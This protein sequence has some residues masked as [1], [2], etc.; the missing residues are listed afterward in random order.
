MDKDDV[1]GKAGGRPGRPRAG[2]GGRGAAPPGAQ[3][4][5]ALAVLGCRGFARPHPSRPGRARERPVGAEHLPCLGRV[6]WTRPVAA[7]YGLGP[8]P[9]RLVV[10]SEAC[11]ATRAET[12]AGRLSR[13]TEEALSDRARVRAS[14][15]VTV[16]GE[17][18]VVEFGGEGVDLAGDLGVRISSGRGLNGTATEAK[19]TP[20]GSAKPPAGHARIPA[21][22][23]AGTSRPNS[24]FPTQPVRHQT[25]RAHRG[26]CRSPRRLPTTHRP[27]PNGSGR[28]GHDRHA[29]RRPVRRATHRAHH[30]APRPG[31]ATRPVRQGSSRTGSSRRRTPIHPFHPVHRC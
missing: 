26:G 8:F 23:G 30:R 24:P 2:I 7:R 12:V 17:Q 29:P 19:T 25:P 22:P 11:G 20:G 31:C 6:I 16:C 27:A 21:N 5:R 10:A 14:A 3:H 15:R 18:A 9:A 4:L 13:H 1:R 28:R